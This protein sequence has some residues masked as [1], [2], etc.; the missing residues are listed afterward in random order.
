MTLSTRFRLSV[1][2]FGL[3]T[4]SARAQTVQPETPAAPLPT[5]AVTAATPAA[6]LMASQVPGKYKTYLNQR[7]A[8]DKEARAAIHM[9]G[10]KQTGGALWLVGGAAFIG[11]VTSQTGSTQDGTGTKTV[12]VSPLGYV[13]MTGLSGGIGIGKLV[14]FN[15]AELYKVLADYDKDHVFPGYVVAKLNKSDY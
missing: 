13:I 2:V 12:T 11:F 8:G 1:G 14:R 5:L 7:Y 9:F 6:L 15:N 3:C 10:R 4:L